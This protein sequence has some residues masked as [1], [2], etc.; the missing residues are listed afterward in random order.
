MQYKTLFRVLLKVLGVWL[1]VSALP[2]LLSDLIAFMTIDLDVAAL[3]DMWWRMWIEPAAKIALG[4]YLFLGGRWIANVAIPSNRPYCAD[5]GYELTAT[6]AESC[7]ECGAVV[8]SRAVDS[9]PP[10]G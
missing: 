3:N 1:I 2:R 6:N 9:P 5:C 7:P 8:A 4:L 10:S